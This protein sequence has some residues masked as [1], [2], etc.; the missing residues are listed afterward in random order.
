MQQS[1]LWLCVISL[2]WEKAIYKIPE[3]L[4]G[5]IPANCTMYIVRSSGKNFT[6]DVCLSGN[7]FIVQDVLSRGLVSKVFPSETLVNESIKLEEKICEQYT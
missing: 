6:M 7:Q 3:I 4:F 2:R 5:T 1:T